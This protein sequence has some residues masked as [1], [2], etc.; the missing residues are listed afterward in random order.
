M[1]GF[2]HEG[3]ISIKR[4]THSYYNSIWSFASTYFVVT[5]HYTKLHQIILHYITLHYITLH[6]TSLH[7]ITL[8]YTTLHY[9]T[10]H[11]KALRMKFSFVTFKFQSHIN[12]NQSGGKYQT[13]RQIFLKK[14]NYAMFKMWF[15][16]KTIS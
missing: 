9:I 7:Y 2:Y 4:G 10:L 16:S 14:G 13:K 1:P 12:I 15:L 11:Y 3:K 8:H 6:Y 5:L